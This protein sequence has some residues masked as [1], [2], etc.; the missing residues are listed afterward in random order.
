MSGLQRQNES[1]GLREAMGRIAAVD[2][3]N[4]ED[5]P[6][7]DRSTV[8]G[9]AMISS[10]SATASMAI[11]SVVSVVGE[12]KMGSL[13]EDIVTQGQAVKIPTGG[14]LPVGADA[15][16]MREFTRDAGNGVLLVLRSVAAGDNVIRRGDDAVAGSVVVSAGHRI[17]VPD[18]GVLASCGADH[19]TVVK[20]PVVTIVT[21]GDEII[22]PGMVPAFGQ[23]RDV[24]SFTLSALAEA[25]GCEAL[26]TEKVPDSQEGLAAVLEAA[27]AKSDVVLVSG[28]SSVGDRDFTT[29]AVQSLHGVKIWFHGVALKPGKPTLMALANETVI[30]G[31]PGHTVAAMTV[32]KEIVEPALL[33]FQGV[34]SVSPR[35]VI[36]AK[37]GAPLHPDAERDEILRVRLEQ[38]E[39]GV[40]AWPL[41]AKS[42]LITVMT[43]AH[44]MVY[45]K[46]GQREMQAGEIV[47]VQ[48]L[49]DRVSGTW[50]GGLR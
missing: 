3:I 43:R 37:L 26:L 18:L 20:K 48:V 25:A 30:F 1:V 19:V 38:L 16:V 23:I 7:F 8:D 12:V 35:F 44:G 49:R 33:A 13:A 17:G 45:T 28:G 15:V 11:P 29:T 47:E 27:V 34:T 36:Q 5:N 46:A 41:P 31:V 42:G 6:P 32:F 40:L 14:M 2:F 50:Q 22:A 4:T 10:D 21:T 24:N 39:G 9:F